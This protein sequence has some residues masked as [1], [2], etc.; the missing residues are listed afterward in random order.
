[1]PQTKIDPGVTTVSIYGD[2][3]PVI[4]KETG[5]MKLNEID[6]NGNIYISQTDKNEVFTFFSG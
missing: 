6:N 4:K 3:V 5:I 2:K 1:M